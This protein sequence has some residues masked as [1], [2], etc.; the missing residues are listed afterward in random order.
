LVLTLTPDSKNRSIVTLSCAKSKGDDFED[1]MLRLNQDS[2]RFVPV[3][4]SVTTKLD[5][6]QQMLA[7]ARTLEPPFTRRSVV[8]S[9]EGV[10]SSSTVDKNLKAACR[11]EDL[12]K[13]NQGLYDFPEM[14][15]GSR[16]ADVDT[17]LSVELKAA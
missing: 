4:S 7:A 15:Q 2:R 8:E 1:L 17:L 10:M 5:G 9:L 11:R 14:K 12:R 3:E 16:L 13:L 6:Y